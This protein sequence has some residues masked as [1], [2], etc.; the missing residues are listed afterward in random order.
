[1]N[2]DF[3]QVRAASK[4]IAQLTDEERSAILCELADMTEARMAD[5]LQANAQ[6]L[7][8]MDPAN[9]NYDRLQLTEARLRDIAADL[10]KVASLPS[11]LGRELK[12][13]ILPNGLELTRVSVPFGV[14]GISAICR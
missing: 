3:S 1:M 8:R 2:T 4:R 10:R 11:P 14:I 13:S 12:H 6:D 5:L 7:Q 9:P